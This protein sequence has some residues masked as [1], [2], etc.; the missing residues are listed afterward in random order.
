M[1]DSWK[2]HEWIHHLQDEVD[3][4]FLY[5]ALAELEL[6]TKRKEI[7]RRLADVEDKHV[8][9][10]KTIFL[11][12]QIDVPV[13][14]PSLKARIQYRLARLFGTQL[15][16]PLLL[17]EEAGEVK[18]YLRFHDQAEGE[19][20][21]SAAYRFATESL[22][23]VS[24]LQS[25]AGISSEPWHQTESGDLLRNIV[26][27]FN[28]GLTANFG[29]VAGVIGGNVSHY[30]VLLSGVA[31]TI[32]D[33]L[34]MGSSGYLAAQ[35]Q[36]EVHDHELEMERQEI[37]L[38][39]EVEAEELA[40]MYEA[41]GIAAKQ[42]REI[43]RDM[44]TDPDKVL[45]EMKREELNIGEATTTPLKEG[46]ITGTA[47]AIGAFIPVA[48]FVV[49]EKEIAIWISFVISML[50]HFGVGAARSL[51]TGRGILRS[52]FDMFAVGFGVAAISYVLGDMLVRWIVGEAP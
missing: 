42:A 3:A 4:G 37:L 8:E 39:P 27:G 43:A 46:V 44:I 14:N 21:K 19:S 7:Y 5:R 33:A 25:L 13:L 51:F 24:S 2:T 41:K 38:M 35:S 47:T 10:W 15:L 20:T 32:A 48:P 12:N 45:N 26:Y 36:K 28:D 29:L 49:F 18:K 52:G 30:V 11:E 40:L 23:H 6:D 16:L 22:E 1:S 50:A 17:R 31:G 34:S 9:L